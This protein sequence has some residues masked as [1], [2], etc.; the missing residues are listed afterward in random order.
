[1]LP[2]GRYAA[3]SG[4]RGECAVQ[5]R[6][7]LRPRADL[8]GRER[9]LAGA[10]CDALLGRPAHGGVAVIGR[11]DVGKGG[12][13]LAGLRRTCR[14]PS[15]PN[16]SSASAR[17]L[18]HRARSSFYLFNQNDKIFLK[19]LD[20]HFLSIYPRFSTSEQHHHS[21]LYQSQFYTRKFLVVTFR[22]E[23]SPK[24]SAEMGFRNC[25]VECKD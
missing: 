17:R 1:M 14:F 9:V 15:P 8:V 16:G 5:K 18:W 10:R 21:N 23:Y 25:L 13:V 6:H 2:D 20:R 12:G 19:A 11:R 22:I 24:Y 3:R 7:N 4:R